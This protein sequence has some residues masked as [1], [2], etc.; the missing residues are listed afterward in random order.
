MKVLTH[1][2]RNEIP[3]GFAALSLTNAGWVGTNSGWPFVGQPALFPEAQADA[4]A[5][6][7]NAFR[8]YAVADN[9]PHPEALSDEIWQWI[10][11]KPPQLNPL[12]S[13]FERIR[14][15]APAMLEAL[16]RCLTDLE[17]LTGNNPDCM[18]WVGHNDEGGPWPEVEERAAKLRALI[19]RIDGE[20]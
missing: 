1:D 19:A 17:W 8:L 11:Q 3:D 2:D 10:G 16:Q 9:M 13:R 4:M 20:A 12:R 15:E 14:A 6:V 18:G 7:W 5:T